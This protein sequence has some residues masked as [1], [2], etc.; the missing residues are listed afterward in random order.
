MFKYSLFLLSFY[1]LILSIIERRLLNSLIIPKNL[2]ISQYSY[3]SFCFIYF[4]F[5]L[6]DGI[7]ILFMN[8]SLHHYEISFFIPGYFVCIK[9]TLFGGFSDSPVAK[10]PHS[11]CSG[12]EFHTWTRTHKLQLRVLM[13][14]DSKYSAITTKFDSPMCSSKD[15]GSQISK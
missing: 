15:P 2:Y 12:P 7:L 6:L 1:L 3:I 13:L 14:Q 9:S 11:Q 4:Y 5:L 8:W 10:T